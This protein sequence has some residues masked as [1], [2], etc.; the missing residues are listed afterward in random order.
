MGKLFL[1]LRP[2]I[3]GQLRN[4]STNAFGTPRWWDAVGKD[5]PCRGLWRGEPNIRDGSSLCEAA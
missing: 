4:A 3:W 1:A 5:P 2:E